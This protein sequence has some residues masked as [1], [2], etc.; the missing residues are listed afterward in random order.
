MPKEKNSDL[1]VNIVTAGV[2]VSLLI[3]GYFALKPKKE[4]IFDDVGSATQSEVAESTVFIGAGIT[5]TISNLRAL[6]DSVASSATIFLMPEFQKLEDFSVSIPVEEMGTVSGRKNPF[7]PTPWK[8]KINAAAI[9]SGKSTSQTST[10]QSSSVASPTGAN[11][12]PSSSGASNP[13]IDS[14]QAL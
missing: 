7:T 2:V 5:R 13:V 14:S 8:I 9:A 4:I 11:A 6:K 10:S 3:A 1:I 12:N